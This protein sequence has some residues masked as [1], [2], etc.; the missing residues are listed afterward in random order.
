MRKN[1]INGSTVHTYN[2]EY[3]RNSYKKK[4][5]EK[6]SSMKKKIVSI[7][8]VAAMAVSLV[9]CGNSSKSD[10]TD[11]SSNKE[12]SS[13]SKETK[14]VKWAQGASGNVLVSIAKE[15]GYF[16]EV[17][18]EVEEVP[19]DEGQLEAVRTG[20]VDIAS[21]SGTMRPLQMIASGDDM[22][23]IGGFMLTGC[24]P[25]VAREDQE[26]NSPEDFLGSKF[27]D[28]KSR[29]CLFHSLVEEGHDLDKEI[30]FA[31]YESDSEKIQAVLKGEIDYA[32]IGTGRMYEVEHT[33]GLKIVT[34]CSDVTPNY[35]CCRMVARNSWVQEN[36]ETVKL[37]DEALIRAMCY[38]ESHREDCVD[39][40]VDQLSA[41]KEYVEAYMLNEHYRINP[42]T[43]KN[44]VV[45]NYNYMVSVG[46]IENLD[47]SVKLE[48]RIYNNIYKEAL[49]EAV[50]KWGDEDK[51]FYD[52][53]V[54][55]YQENN[56]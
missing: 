39:L 19:L 49:D 10:S 36:E 32:T 21:N 44:I 2:P 30:E 20:Q 56:E 31:T 55:F 38:F 45:D 40:M 43:V 13:E 12:S 9:A 54:K 25:V 16:D 5:K 50:E 1:S 18:V 33:D 27:A 17:G 41:N 4:A 53:A 8:L 52:N 11:S 28:A 24:M 22:A 6:G 46:G 42:D 26:W 48:D 3:N 15:Q 29:Y 23:I 37:I 34:Y 47:T 51:D 14:K 35:S 7:L